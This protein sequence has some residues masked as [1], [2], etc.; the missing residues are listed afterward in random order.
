M[1][2]RFSRVKVIS[3]VARRRR[4][5]AEQKLAVV[6]ETMQ[7][8]ISLSYVARR[9][10]L[11]PAQVFRWRRLVAKDGQQATPRRR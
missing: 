8:G 6:T 3:G 10:G 9:H 7:P 4:F 2:D 11:A 1:S 5:T